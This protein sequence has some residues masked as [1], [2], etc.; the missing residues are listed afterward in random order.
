MI[1]IIIIYQEH[2]ADIANKISN[3]VFYEKAA[4]S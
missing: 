3:S 2:I 1:I 4:F